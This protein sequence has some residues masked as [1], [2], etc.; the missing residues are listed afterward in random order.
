MV[1]LQRERGREVPT[2]DKAAAET[3]K[4]PLPADTKAREAELVRRIAELEAKL[5]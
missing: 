5:S 2:Q 3:G 4:A 1:R